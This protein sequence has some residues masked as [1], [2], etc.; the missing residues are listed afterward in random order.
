MWPENSSDI[1]PYADPSARPAI[2]QAAA[3]VG[4]P[5]L[6]GAVVGDRADH[7]WFNRAIVWS[8]DGRRGSTTTRRHPVP[9]GEYIPLRSLL[10]PRIPALG[11]D[12]Q[13]HGAR[14]PTGRAAGRSGDRAASLMCF[15]V[16]YDG[17]LRD[18]VDG[19]ADLIVVP[20][21]NATYTGTGQIEQQF[22]MS[23]LRAIETGR[24]VVVAS[25]NGISGIVAPD[26]HVVAAGAVAEAGGAGAGRRR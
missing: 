6:M 7:G 18:V 14:H 22:A 4:A 2:G 21:N 5:L 9:F 20:T 13:R 10:A 25:T 11:P 26:G 15:E 17:L 3:A 24:Y 12:P 1:D 8:T 19:G 23:R 16:A